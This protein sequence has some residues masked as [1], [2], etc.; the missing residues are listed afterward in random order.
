M[1]ILI[2][3]AAGPCAT[4]RVLIALG[5]AACH[6]RSL[7]AAGKGGDP[8]KNQ[9]RRGKMRLHAP[10]ARIALFRGR[11]ARTLPHT[12]RCQERRLQDQVSK[13][14]ESFANQSVRRLFRE[15]DPI[16]MAYRDE[17]MRSLRAAR[18]V[19]VMLLGYLLTGV[20]ALSRAALAQDLEPSV[21]PEI[22]EH[23]AVTAPVLTPT[24]ETSGTAWVPQ[25]TPMYGVHRPWHGWDLRLSG[26]AFVQAL[27]EPGPRHRTGG[28]GTRQ[29][30][31]INWVMA[32]AR[33]DVAGGRF[34]VRTMFSAEPW[35]VLGCGSLNFLATGEICNGDTIHDRQQP[36]DLFMELA[37]EYERRLR[38][39]WRWQL[40]AGL[41]GE[42]ALGPPGYLH[43]ASAIVNPV[44]PLTHHWLDSTHVSFGV[45]TFGVHN[46]RWK[47][48][49][50]A[51]NG[52]EPDEGRIALDLGAFDSAAVRLSFLPTEAWAVQVS[53]ASLRSSRT[54]IVGQPRR[55]GLRVTASAT[56]HRTIGRSGIWATTLAY[57]KNHA[58]E[59][60]PLTVFDASTAAG[61]VESSITSSGRHT[62]FGRG[63]I[64][65][66]PAHHLHAHEY[67]ASVFAVGKLQLG[68]VRHF[69]VRKGVRPGIGGA[70]SI[71]LVSPQLAPRY[72]GNIVPGFA[73]FFNLQPARH[74]M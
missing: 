57:G 49:A 13:R 44:G 68:Y 31:S 60:T 41:A 20:L 65:D 73:V 14:C 34:G 15:L 52:R 56:Y 43:R 3:A 7:N 27:Y 46:Q 61:L 24:R 22:H 21:S 26:A 25:A 53:G 72:S 28:F 51:F 12:A 39:R 42:P 33:R 9:I 35:T 29:A 59:N 54:D 40:Y 32:Q 36:H 63:E 10:L 71:S 18:F 66:M 11:A 4:S 58:T 38:G 23:V 69:S 70:M 62:V 64:V 48:E 55:P 37:T 5:G 47:I 67:G 2:T 45:M 1:P 8:Q 19:S 74:R 30:G 50:S 17:L 6:A 16:L